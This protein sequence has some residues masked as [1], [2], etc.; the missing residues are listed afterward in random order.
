MGF[1]GIVGVLVVALGFV[2][3]AVDSGSD[4]G[5]ANRETV[6][7]DSAPE[8]I[9]GDPGQTD[10]APVRE[11][12]VE[13]QQIVDI[14]RDVSP[15]VVQVS[16]GFGAGS[17]FLIDDEGHILTNNH[18]I[19]GASNVSVMLSDGTELDGVVLGTDPVDDV[20]LLKVDPAEL[21]GIE[22]LT[23]ADSDNLLPG[24][25]AIAIGSPFGLDGTITV[26][27]ISGLDRS[28]T[29]NDGRPITGVIQTDAALNPGNSGGPLLNSSGE[30]IGINTAIE[31]QSADGVGYS[32]PINTAKNV[33][34]RLEQGETVS[35]PWLGIAGTTVNSAVADELNLTADDGV[36]VLDVVPG[37]P[38]DE[39]GLIGGG[40]TSGG[41]PGGGGDVITAA[42]GEEL[43]SI[44]DLIEFLNRKAVGEEISLTVDRG[45]ATVSVEVT[46]AAYSG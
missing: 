20:A 4:S 11:V 18:V 28:L 7:S 8:T 34:S 32:V 21:S 10:N 44:D 17:G 24:Q 15:A 1:L 45:G 46:L 36:Y 33:L 19:E 43:R 30:V 6:A 26:G 14:Y 22:P 13:E 12:L 27:V 38:A 39:A 23:L 40:T 5:T 25:L 37:S 9:S 2:L 31:G 29:G 3:V 42:D 41:E 16:V 35:R